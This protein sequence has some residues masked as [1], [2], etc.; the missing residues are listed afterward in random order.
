[1][2]L[3]DTCVYRADAAVSFIYCK[4]VSQ[5]GSQ[6]FIDG[7]L[8]FIRIANAAT[9]SATSCAATCSTIASA[10]AAS[11]PAAVKFHWQVQRTSQ[12]RRCAAVASLLRCLQRLSSRTAYQTSYSGV[13]SIA[14]VG[15]SIIRSSIPV[16]GTTAASAACT[17]RAAFTAVARR[18]TASNLRRTGSR[19]QMPQCVMQAANAP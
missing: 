1:M 11:K 13:S 15:T 17:D 16:V 5:H 19:E 18:A 3:R 4:P 9:C 12:V 10:A 6:C 2:C 8:I 7:L 14:I